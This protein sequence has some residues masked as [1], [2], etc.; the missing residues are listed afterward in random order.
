MMNA[1]TVAYLNAMMVESFDG[2]D[3]KPASRWT[4]IGVAFPHKD[5]TGFNVQLNALPVDGK[6]VLVPPLPEREDEKPA[7]RD[8]RRR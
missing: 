2:A 7:P 6:V 8:P 1:Q 5:G 4:K 3:G